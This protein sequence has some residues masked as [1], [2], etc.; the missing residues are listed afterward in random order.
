[1]IRI[2]AREDEWLPMRFEA[3]RP[4]LRL[5]ALAAL[6]TMASLWLLHEDR[7]RW[8]LFA[9][10]PLL[11]PTLTSILAG[12]FIVA[13]AAKMT[14]QGN[15]NAGHVAG[16]LLMLFVLGIT[17]LHGK[18]AAIASAMPQ[19][20]IAI[21]RG[22]TVMVSGRMDRHLPFRL[23]EHLDPNHCEVTIT[24]SGG[25]IFAA[26]EVA[27]RIQ[28]VGCRVHVSSRCASSCLTVWALAPKRSAE[29]DAEFGVHAYTTAVPGE[30][31]RNLLDRKSAQYIA[32]LR[33]IGFPEDV[34]LRVRG[35]SSADVLW[36]SGGEL[37]QLGVEFELRSTPAN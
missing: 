2:S 4:V 3:C 5:V 14:R 1:M 24:S 11:A 31:G 6:I 21:G 8:E 37:A 15:S 22:G 27:R 9:R 12:G 35:G 28:D 10:Y 36:L 29:E 34:A 16:G 30:M 25:D 7:Q 17:L 33:Q 20:T 19:A 26:G 23:R 32:A 13:V 18:S